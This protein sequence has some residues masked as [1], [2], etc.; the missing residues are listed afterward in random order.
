MNIVYQITSSNLHDFGEQIYENIR[1]RLDLFVLF[2]SQC[3]K[4]T[5]INCKI[6]VTKNIQPAQRIPLYS[7]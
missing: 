2:R 5:S 6:K 1:I 3:D 7:I 4:S